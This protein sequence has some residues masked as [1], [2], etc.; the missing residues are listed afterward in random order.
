MIIS[1]ADALGYTKPATIQYVSHVRY[2]DLQ[3]GLTASPNTSDSTNL[4]RTG[5]SGPRITMYYGAGDVVTDA[6]N[7]TIC[8]TRA[9]KLEW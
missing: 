2:L 1:D 9:N 3:R 5:A 6:P 4:Q 8:K 7:L